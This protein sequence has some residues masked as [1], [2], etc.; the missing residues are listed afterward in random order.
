[1]NT[2]ARYSHQPWNTGN[3]V[4]QKPLS[5]RGCKVKI[6]AKR[7]EYKKEVKSNGDD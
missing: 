2:I 4:E 1:M 7:D 6:D 5:E 3:R